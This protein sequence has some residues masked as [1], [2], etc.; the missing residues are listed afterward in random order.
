MLPVVPQHLVADTV[1]H[2][3][4]SVVNSLSYINFISSQLPV[5]IASSFQLDRFTRRGPS[6]LNA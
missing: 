6:A 3:L 5:I 1:S 2:M 4:Y